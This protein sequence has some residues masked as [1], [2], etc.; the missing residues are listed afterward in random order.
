V[1]FG[2]LASRFGLG[3]VLL[4]A[5]GGCYNF[6]LAGPEDA[7]PV[8]P[9]GLVDVTIEYRQPQACL[10]TP[11]R[12]DDL[13]VFYGSWMRQGQEIILTLDPGGF[14]WRGLARAVPVNFPPRDDPYFVRIFDPHLR[15]TETLGITA[16]R[17]KVGGEPLKSFDAYGTPIESGLLFID[18]N[19]VGHSPY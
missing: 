17:L 19:G 9:P 3:A 4:T 10:N 2:R 16:E 11:S 7:P 14:I 8:S 5:L 15:D 1:T 6:H 12:C 13:V 18:D